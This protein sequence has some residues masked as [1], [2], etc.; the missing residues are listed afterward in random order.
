LKRLFKVLMLLAAG[1]EKQATLALEVGAQENKLHVDLH[2]RGVAVPA[3]VVQTIESQLRPE[4]GESTTMPAWGANLLVARGIVGLHGGQL[5]VEAR[6]ENLHLFGQ[7]PFQ[8]EDSNSG[9]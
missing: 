6:P 7:L 9:Q 1:Q 4:E 2:L 8:R 3:D 5:E